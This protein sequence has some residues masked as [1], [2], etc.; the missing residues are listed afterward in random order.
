MLQIPL[1]VCDVASGGDERKVI[2]ITECVKSIIVQRNTLLN[3][4]QNSAKQPFTALP[5]GTAE[6]LRRPLHTYVAAMS[7]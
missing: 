4:E 6:V 5:D 7:H 1:P 2:D 3:E